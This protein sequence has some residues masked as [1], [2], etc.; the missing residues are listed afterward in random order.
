MSSLAVMG[1]P[2]SFGP[3]GYLAR[4]IVDEAISDNSLA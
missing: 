3:P 2:C 4:L 1:P